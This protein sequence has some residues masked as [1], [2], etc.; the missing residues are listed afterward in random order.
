[1]AGFYRSFCLSN[2]KSFLFHANPSSNVSAILLFN[3]LV[4]VT[5]EGSIACKRFKKRNVGEY[6]LYSCIFYFIFEIFQISLVI[7]NH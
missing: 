4:I 2:S 6:S 3:G 5:N 7:K 1:M